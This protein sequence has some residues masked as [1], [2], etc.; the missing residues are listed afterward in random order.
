MQDVMELCDSLSVEALQLLA[1]GMRNIKEGP[2]I[3][4]SCARDIL[5]IWARLPHP[6]ASDLAVTSNNKLLPDKR[7]ELVLLFKNPPPDLAEILK[8]AGR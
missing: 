6:P 8:E 7:A 5:Y 1:S 3:R 2:K 4:R